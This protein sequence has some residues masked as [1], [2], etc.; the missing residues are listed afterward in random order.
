MF[1][2]AGGI[3]VAFFVVMALAAGPRMVLAATVGKLIASDVAPVV[4]FVVTVRGIVVPF[5]VVTVLAAG[6]G[7]VLVATV[8]KLIAPEVFLVVVEA[9][10]DTLD[11]KFVIDIAI[12]S[13][14]VPL[15]N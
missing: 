3:V 15:G 2:V 11:I 10:V 8:G 7:M 1:V 9:E 13:K 12:T 6:A 5:F 14:P 4:M